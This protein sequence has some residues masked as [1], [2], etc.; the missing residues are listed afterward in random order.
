MTRN[1]WIMVTACLGALAAGLLFPGQTAIFAPFPKACM[2]GVLFFN[3][4]DIRPSEV[5]GS[6]RGK[7]PRTCGFLLFKMLLLPALAWGLCRLVLPGYALSAL[8]LG[9]MSCGVAGPVFAAMYGVSAAF[10]TALVLF[11]SL[12]VPLTLPLL[13]K[14][15][16]GLSLNVSLWEMIRLLAEVVLIPFAAAETA[17]RFLP[18]LIEPCRKYRF[19][20]VVLLFVI[21]NMGIFS[22]YGETVANHPEILTGTVGAA[23][24]L[25]LLF[26]FLPL[27]LYRKD[28]DTALNT[29]LG[30]GIMNNAIAVIF[31][32]EQLGPTEALTAALYAIPYFLC[33]IPLR[34]AARTLTHS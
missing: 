23:S 14:A 33:L 27:F 19:S 25:A 34:F 12:L 31:A 9:G 4:L 5:V 16:A 32:A 10:A 24:L 26:F 15:L 2:M 30:C 22:G 18:I 17:R 8:L 13:V 21:T 1:D 28:P 3:F 29:A 11:T 7:G 6:I 20:A